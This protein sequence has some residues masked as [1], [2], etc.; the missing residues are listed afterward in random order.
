[1][2]PEHV[3]QHE[4]LETALAEY[5]IKVGGKVAVSVTV[6]EDQ[7]IAVV[8][9]GRAY[10]H[11]NTHLRMTAVLEAVQRTCREDAGVVYERSE[12]APNH[13]KVVGQ[14]G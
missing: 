11:P 7:S 10:L 8:T 12:K 5:L 13:G 14:E 1:M 3:A 9:T 6:M 4:M 2:R